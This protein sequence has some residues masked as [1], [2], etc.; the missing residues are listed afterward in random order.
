MVKNAVLGV[1]SSA[2][3]DDSLNAI[4]KLTQYY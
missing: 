4:G 2:W 1:L 3:F